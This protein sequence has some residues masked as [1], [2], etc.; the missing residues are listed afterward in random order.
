MRRADE[1][2]MNPIKVL[3]V[4]DSVTVRQLLVEALAV[5]TE[6]QVVG[7][8]P[9]GALALTMLPRLQPDV[10]V[11]DIDM[12][13]MDGLEFLRRVRPMYPRLPLLVFSTYTTHGAATTLQALWFGASDYVAKPT[14]TGFEAAVVQ[15]RQELLPRIKAFARRDDRN[16]PGASALRPARPARMPAPLPTAARVP[17]R[18]SVVAIGTSTGGPRALADVL[19]AL[20]GDFPV[21]VLVVQHMP[22]LFTRHLADGLSAQC[23]LPVREAEHGVAL[24]PG[25]VWIAPGDHHLTVGRDGATLRTRLD[26]GPT[27]NACRP[28]VNPLFRSV[29]EVFGPGALGVVLTGMGQDGLDGAARIRAARGSVIAQDEATSVVWGMPGSVTRAGHADT[30]LPL[31]RIAEAILARVRAQGGRRAA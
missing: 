31:D 8:A 19:G 7:T 29:A 6:I 16:T 27:E 22:P 4:D 24:E 13:V 21:P 25:T 26:Q 1:P 3:L 10:V 20:P 18:A 17:P 9:N 30:V 2:A 28:S 23:E 14:A 11:L 12:P 15:A 5:D